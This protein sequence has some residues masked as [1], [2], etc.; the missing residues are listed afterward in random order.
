MS[1][2]K[3]VAL[4]GICMA[5]IIGLFG[6]FTVTQAKG[7][8]LEKNSI[9]VAEPSALMN[10][11]DFDVYDG[12]IYICNGS[13][14]KVQV[15]D[16]EGNFI[17]AYKAD[18][19]GDI[20]VLATENFM[21]IY[22]MRGSYVEEIDFNGKKLKEYDIPPVSGWKELISSNEK[23]KNQDYSKGPFVIY[24][25]REGENYQLINILGYYSIYQLEDGGKTK[26]FSSDS[27]ASFLITLIALCLIA[28]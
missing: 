11:S 26:I 6:L 16:F 25:G 4:S 19:G 17:A 10:V 18:T 1:G 28:S 22:Y 2:G 24:I 20:N 13:Y 3:K 23:P 12:K 14:Q 9:K 8:Y 27:L 7:R 5:L 21:Y 15:Y